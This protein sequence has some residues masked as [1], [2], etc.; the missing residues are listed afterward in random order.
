MSSNIT[1]QK[2]QWVDHQR[3]LMAQPDLLD[4][5][6]EALPFVTGI[7]ALMEQASMVDAYEEVKLIETR[8]RGAIAK[9]DARRNG[10][11]IN[12]QWRELPKGAAQEG[13]Y[14]SSL[15]WYDKGRVI[16]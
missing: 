2:P 1:Q 5:A 6:S 15:A 13:V 7:M 14:R 9:E 4:A 8:L 11:H 3:W 16:R 10:F 12:G